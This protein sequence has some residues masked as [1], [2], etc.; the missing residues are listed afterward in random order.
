MKI[1][2][3]VFSLALL[4]LAACGTRW[5]QVAP[6]TPVIECTAL[7]L[8]A[9]GWV[10]DTVFTN[11]RRI[12]VVKH[13]EPGF[14]VDTVT[15]QL[16]SPPATQHVRIESRWWYG[17]GDEHTHAGSI[18]DSQ[19]EVRMAMKSCGVP[20]WEHR[21]LPPL[22]GCVAGRLAARGFGVEALQP[23]VVLAT[24]RR[25]ARE[26]VVRASLLPPDSAGRVRFASDSYAVD[27]GG[28]RP[29]ETDSV[30]HREVREVFSDCGVHGYTN[31]P[32]WKGPL[33]GRRP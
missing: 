6:G 22:V 20:V 32:A 21:P 3:A 27:D 15:A 19:V 30:V 17:E 9:R 33:P 16:L 10:V 13:E 8:A 23:N 5:I 1:I 26:T 31:R 14:S 25:N 18:L 7:R 4:L 29:V 28:R 2:H 24:F 12:R 11:A